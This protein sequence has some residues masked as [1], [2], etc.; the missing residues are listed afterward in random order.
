MTALAYPVTALQFDGIVLHWYGLAYLVSFVWINTQS[1]RLLRLNVWNC[2]QPPFLPHSLSLLVCSLAFGVVGGARL[3]FVVEAIRTGVAVGPTSIGGGMSSFGA[4]AGALL[5]LAIF[6]CFNHSPLRSTLDLV[7]FSAPGCILLIRLANFVNGDLVGIPVKS[8][9]VVTLLGG[10]HVHPVALYEA[11]G[12]GLLPLLILRFC[13]LRLHWLSRPGALA[14]L[15]VLL[16]AFV[17]GAAIGWREVPPGVIPVSQS[18]DLLCCIALA[19]AAII[20]LSV[21]RERRSNNTSPAVCTMPACRSWVAEAVYV[22]VIASVSLPL[23]GCRGA[24]QAPPNPIALVLTNP[25]ADPQCQCANSRGAYAQNTSD[26]THQFSWAAAIKDTFSNNPVPNATGSSALGPGQKMFLGCTIYAPTN[27]CRYQ[28]TYD[29]TQ[30][31]VL[32]TNAKPLAAVFG[33]VSSP[34]ISSCKASCES[35][36]KDD[37]FPCLSLGVRYYQ[38]VA[39]LAQMVDSAQKI[40]KN[41]PKAEIMKRYNLQASDDTCQRGDIK[42]AGGKLINDGG[43]KF[44]VIPSADLPTRVLKALNIK[45]LEGPK[46]LKMDTILPQHL[47]A[48]SEPNVRALDAS[49]VLVFRSMNSAPH[50]TFEGAGSQELN[51]NFSGAVLG[52]AEIKPLQGGAQ[53]IIATQN[54]CMSV[55]EP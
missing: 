25:S 32:R 28:A 8:P 43:T 39:P 17:R 27:Q 3:G 50:I 22:V 46:P 40:G 33:A 20:L 37:P 7:A 51:K 4:F 19:I 5:A 35:S 54:G 31:S 49:H 47:E 26:S 30:Q 42:T 15:F 34:S 38:A 48:E 36:K 24:A 6:S 45:S 1:K 12:E 53:V 10:L 44:C 55:E 29:I 18:A 21:A 11:L 52:S 13:I 41:V 23:S 14:G 2:Q 16:Y 9:W